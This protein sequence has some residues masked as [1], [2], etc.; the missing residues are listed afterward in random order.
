M[1]IGTST[2][3]APVGGDGCATGGAAAAAAAAAGGDGGTSTSEASGRI[4]G[5]L[6][7]TCDEFASMVQYQYMTHAA[8]SCYTS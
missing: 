3:D 2:A 7:S 8:T 6:G 1:P 5:E 4:V